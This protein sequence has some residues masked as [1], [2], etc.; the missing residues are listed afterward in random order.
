MPLTASCWSCFTSSQ[1]V[2][3]ESSELKCPFGQ[4]SPGEEHP[5]LPDGTPC[6]DVLHFQYEAGRWGAAKKLK[7]APPSLCL[8]SVYGKPTAAESAAILC[9][10]GEGGLVFEAL[11]LPDS[12]VARILPPRHRSLPVRASDFFSSL[13]KTGDG[14]LIFNGV[15]N[16]WPGLTC[17]ELRSITCKVPCITYGTKTINKWDAE[18]HQGTDPDPSSIFPTDGS[19]YSVK[20]ILR[21]PPWT[22]RGWSRDNP[23]HVWWFHSQ[24]TNKKVAYGEDIIRGLREVS[25]TCEEG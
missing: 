9:P 20:A 3:H 19:K 25:V 23:G 4:D 24:R 16:G 7:E 14:R 13:V 12:P 21:L 5:R 18:Q 8:N 11:L 17:M 22:S 6:D 15:L 1:N 10:S 2:W